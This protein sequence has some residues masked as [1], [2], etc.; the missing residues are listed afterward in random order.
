M[1]DDFDPRDTAAGESG[2]LPRVFLREPG[3]QV[4][5]KVGSERT[6]CYMTAPGED[7]YHRLMDGE[8]ILFRGDEKL[9][10]PCAERR[11]LLSFTSRPLRDKP[12]ELELDAPRGEPG[13]EV[14]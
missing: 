2:S 3:W 4:G 11:G 12:A 9:C 7:F 8:I 13:Y 10:L 6:F 1:I 14:R 5:F